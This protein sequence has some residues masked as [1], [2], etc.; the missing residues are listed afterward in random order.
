MRITLDDPSTE[1]TACG[2]QPCLGKILNLTNPDPSCGP[3][4]CPILPG[5]TDPKHPALVTLDFFGGVFPV[6][7]T[8]YKVV[9]HVGT[10]VP[11][12]VKVKGAYNAPC[13][14]KHKVK[15]KTGQIT[16]VVALLQGDPGL[17]RR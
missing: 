14:A 5:Y 10:P 13:I 3:P 6:T 17:P 1:P 11:T 12:C 8:L 9:N 15:S 4:P 2:G 16:D 7:S